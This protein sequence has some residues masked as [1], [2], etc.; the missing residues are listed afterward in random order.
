MA[1]YSLKKDSVLKSLC[2]DLAEPFTFG[3][4]L[5]QFQCK[6]I[7]NLLNQHQDLL[8]E[9]IILYFLNQLKIQVYPL[10]MLERRSLSNKVSFEIPFHRPFWC[11]KSNPN[12]DYRCQF[13]IVINSII[14]RTTLLHVLKSYGYIEKIYFSKTM[15]SC[16]VIFR[17]LPCSL[18]KFPW[19]YIQRYMF[20][21]YSMLFN[22]NYPNIRA[23]CQ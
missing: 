15:R 20:P 6:N 23:Q 4:F 14:T 19:I 21:V 2:Q 5:N 16:H 13:M 1:L 11:L 7:I 12:F 9:D 10:P 22:D 18:K 3:E 17:T 8:L